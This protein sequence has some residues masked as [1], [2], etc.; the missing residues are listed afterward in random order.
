MRHLDESRAC[1]AGERSCVM[2]GVVDHGV[3]WQPSFCR[4]AQESVLRVAAPEE[5]K[6]MLADLRTLLL[7]LESN[8][9]LPLAEM[10]RTE[11]TYF[12]EGCDGHQESEVVRLAGAL[13]ARPRWEGRHYMCEKRFGTAS[14]RVVSIPEA[15]RARPT[16]QASRVPFRRRR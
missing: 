15:I 11:V 2:G 7:Y 3:L 9:H 6:G 16:E 5:R 13:G 1:P 4:K 10:T 12:T 14:Y 8:P